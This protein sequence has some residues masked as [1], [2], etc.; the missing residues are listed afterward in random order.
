MNKKTLLGG[1]GTILVLLLSLLALVGGNNQPDTDSSADLGRETQFAQVQSGDLIEFWKK[2]SL[3]S[4]DQVECVRN[5]SRRT[6]F[7]D[8]LETQI[9]LTGVGS[10]T[11][12]VDVATSSD[13][14][15]IGGLEPITGGGYY[16]GSST[17]GVD[18]KLTASRLPF[19]GIVH[20]YI[21]ATNSDATLFDV[22]FGT[23]SPLG[24]DSY[25]SNTVSTTTGKSPAGLGWVTIP[26]AEYACVLLMATYEDPLVKP[27]NSSVETVIA[28]NNCEQ[29]TSTNR[30]FD[31]DVFFNF[32]A[33]STLQDL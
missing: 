26:E 11:M 6:I 1:A 14:T 15:N 18:S 30:G 25:F 10:T 29:A 21:I 3:T 23:S 32:K 16:S 12:R 5:I 8:P 24:L 31:V 27:C 2:V 33:T 13:G 7:I 20:N 4:G 9:H 19:G 17:V 28:D 22:E